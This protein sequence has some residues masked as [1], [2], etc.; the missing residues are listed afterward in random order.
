M[1]NIDLNTVRLSQDFAAMAK[2]EK[3]LVHVPVRKPAKHQFVRVH[4]GEDY[5]L[6]VGIIAIDGDDT[7]LV[8]PA[9]VGAVPE[10][11]KPVRLHLYVTRHGAPALWPV[12]LPG[13]DG[14][15]NPWYASAAEAAEVAIK[16]WIRLVPNREVGA[17]DV[18]VAESIPTEPTWPDKSMEEL[19]SK[20]FADKFIE[21]EDHPLLR[22]LLGIG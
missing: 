6:E 21:D 11:V 12:K 22:E 15:T 16:K 10:L 17:Y 8:H 7:Y 13:E 5:R 14:K 4:P 9:V 3:L 20:A 19:V 1:G 18:I 2:T